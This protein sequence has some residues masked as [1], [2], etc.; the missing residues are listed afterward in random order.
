VH[1]SPELLAGQLGYL[2]EDEPELRSASPEQ[3]ATRLNRDDRYSR[4]RSE[5]PMATDAEIAQ[6]VGEFDDRITVA[7]VQA[8]LSRV[9]ADPYRD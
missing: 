6:R 8:A 9:R 1:P 5:Y 2:F 3:L 4:A 7:D